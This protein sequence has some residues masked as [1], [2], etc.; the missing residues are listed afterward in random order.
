M[1]YMNPGLKGTSKLVKRNPKAETLY[2]TIPAD[3]VKEEGFPFKDK[4]LIKI[5]LD[6][7]NQW[8]IISKFD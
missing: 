1:S 2:L 3:I 7:K 4:E 6:K 5:E 8:L